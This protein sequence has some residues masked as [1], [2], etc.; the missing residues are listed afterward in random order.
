MKVVLVMGFG[1]LARNRLRIGL[2]T[3]QWFLVQLVESMAID[4]NN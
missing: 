1:L 3:S 2:L 4:Y